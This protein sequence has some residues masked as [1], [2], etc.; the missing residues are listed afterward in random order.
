MYKIIRGEV[1][2]GKGRGKRE[3]LFFCLFVC[4]WLQQVLEP[5]YQTTF[6]ETQT[7]Q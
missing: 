4:F 3:E 7:R 5:R 2:K 1:R 6:H